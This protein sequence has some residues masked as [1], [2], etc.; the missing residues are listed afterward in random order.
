MAKITKPD[1][2]GETQEQATI[3]VQVQ[4]NVHFARGGVEKSWRDGDYLSFP[5]DEFEALPA[6]LKSR[7]KVLDSVEIKKG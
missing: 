3:Y 1:A 5:L 2:T 4:G 6:D 7:L